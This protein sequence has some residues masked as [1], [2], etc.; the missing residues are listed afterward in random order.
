ME[1]Q[2]IQ[3]MLRNEEER[4]RQNLQNL[5]HQHQIRM[6]ALHKKEEE[7]LKKRSRQRQRRIEYL[8]K[9]IA[10][11]KE[12]E[13]RDQEWWTYKCIDSV[14]NNYQWEYIPETGTW[15]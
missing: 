7:N 9:R 11:L 1:F 13:R 4:Y 10:Q 12:E 8:Y 15:E 14:N 5:E 6:Q 3:K 2:D